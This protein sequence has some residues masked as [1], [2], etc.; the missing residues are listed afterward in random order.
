[1]SRKRKGDWRLPTILELSTLY[2][3]H[4]QSNKEMKNKVY[5]SST[6]Y[7]SNTSYAW[8]VHFGYGRTNYGY[9]T[10]TL[11]VRY[12]RNTKNGLKWSKV[13]I[14]PMTWYEAM[15]CAEKMNKEGR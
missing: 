15:K 2:S 11:Y 8:G 4:F 9:K 6:T 7:A 3:E 12:V 5:W 1:M 14:I 10:H 13:A